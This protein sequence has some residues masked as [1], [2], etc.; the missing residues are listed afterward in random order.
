MIQKICYYWNVS[1]SKMRK[2]QIVKQNVKMNVIFT[3]CYHIKYR[4]LMYLFKTWTNVFF[5]RRYDRGSFTTALELRGK[6]L[7]LATYSDVLNAH[8]LGIVEIYMK[9]NEGESG[10]GRSVTSRAKGEGSLD[11][12]CKGGG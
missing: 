1:N 11:F 3:Y 9:I 10:V 5:F 12:G 7:R 8:R 6:V 2:I 4:N